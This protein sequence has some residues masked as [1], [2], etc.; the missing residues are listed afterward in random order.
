MQVWSREV[1]WDVDMIVTVK[2]EDSLSQRIQIKP[3]QDKR[4]VVKQETYGPIAPGMTKRFIVTIQASSA[5][6][7]GKLK[8]EI[9]VMTKSDIFKVPVEALV[10]SQEEFDKQNQEA[11]A[12]TGKAITNSRVKNR[13]RSSIAQSRQKSVMAAFKEQQAAEE[14]KN[15]EKQQLT[16]KNEQDAGQDNSEYNNE[17]M[18]NLQWSW[19]RQLFFC[20]QI[21]DQLNDC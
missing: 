10:L 8:E 12:E 17:D 13:L 18:D 21:D 14:Q 16:S 9:Q 7:L 5:E 6:S 20:N 2:N 15:Q 1:G 3:T 4:L 11:L 19:R